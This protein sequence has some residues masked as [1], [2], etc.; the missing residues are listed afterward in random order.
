ML[1]RPILFFLLIAI[2]F[3]GFSQVK[4]FPETNYDLDGDG[5]EDF[6]IEDG[7]SYDPYNHVYHYYSKIIP[8]KE[9]EIVFQEN[10]LLTTV[11]FEFGD[12]ISKNLNWSTESIY[13]YHGYFNFPEQYK[14]NSDYFFGVRIKMENSYHYGWIRFRGG[15]DGGM[16]DAAIQLTPDIPV[17]AGEGINSIKTIVDTVIHQHNNNSWSDYMVR[18]FPPYREEYINEYRLFISK[19]NDTDEITVE[20]LRAIS[21]TNYQKIMSGSKVFEITLNNDLKDLDDEEIKQGEEYRV[22][23]LSISNDTTAFSHTYNLTQP[24]KVRTIL[25]KPGAPLV[26]DFG[27]TGT[28]KDIFLRFSS[29]TNEEFTESYRL[30]IVPEQ[31]ADTFN[32]QKAADVSPQ[33]SYIIEPNKDFEYIVEEA[34]LEDIYGNPVENNTFYKAFVYAVPDGVQ[35]SVG[36]ISAVSNLFYLS[37]PNQFYTGQTEGTGIEFFVNDS[38]KRIQ[39]SY[40]DIDWDGK[41]DLKMTAHV[42]AWWYKYDYDFKYWVHT[43]DS[44]EVLIDAEMNN[45]A[46]N[47]LIGDPIFESRDWGAGKILLTSGKSENG[48]I[49]GTGNFSADYFSKGILGFRKIS[50]NDTLFGWVNIHIYGDGTRFDEYAYQ[51]KSELTFSDSTLSPNFPDTIK[52]LFVTYPNP[53][54]DGILNIALKE[55]AAGKDYHI[56]VFNSSGIKMKHILV[57]EK[58]T[59]FNLNALPRGLYFVQLTTPEKQETQKVL[60][61]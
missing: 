52:S 7:L 49:I 21:K 16:R 23:V 14:I 38:N 9:G 34:L 5:F 3:S 56:D 53:N 26:L 58:L 57:T 24:F 22:I 6:I 60:V 4:H 61:Q 37:K 33:N 40:L 17:L 45:H 48:S 35:S 27:N 29:N 51:K 10:S 36:A 18:F 25:S 12:T 1:F 39:T 47:N 31:E 20:K 41:D 59:Q 13:I 50:Q 43:I 28:S 42:D 46:Q 11:F 8:Q 44:T 15:D 54:N 2:H 32:L 19:A 30:I 55:F